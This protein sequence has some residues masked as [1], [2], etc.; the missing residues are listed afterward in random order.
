ASVRIGKA[1]LTDTV[2]EEIR[3]QLQS[4]DLVKVK[5]NKGLFEREQRKDVWN[6]LADNTASTLVLQRGNIGV[7]WRR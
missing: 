5:V 2:L 1:G 6:Y 7:L 4:R 3:Q